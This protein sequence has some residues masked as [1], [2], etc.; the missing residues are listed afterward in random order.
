MAWL[1]QSHRLKREFGDDAPWS[2]GWR[3]P[4]GRSQSRKIGSRSRAEKFA[5]KIEGQIAAGTYEVVQRKTWDGFREKY[6]AYLL[7]NLAPT[8]RES[9]GIALDHFE[10][11]VKPRRLQTINAEAVDR[12][13]SLRRSEKGQKSATVSVA[14]VNR[15]LRVIKAAL[16]VANEWEYLAKVPKIRMLREPKKLP[17]YVTPAHFAIIY[18]ACQFATKPKGLPYAAADWWKALVTF[19]YLT[20]WRIS[21]PLALMRK[22][23]DLDAGQVVTRAAHNKGKRDDLVPVH[24]VV[25]EH[26]QKL[27]SFSPRMFPWPHNRRTLWLEFHHIQESAVDADGKR[28]INLPCPEEGEHGHTCNE[29]CH[30][31]G[32]H[33]LR[34]AFA[35]V[36]AEMMTADSLQTLMRHKS[37]TTT[38]RYIN[39]A[40]QVNRAVEKI[41]VPEILTKKQA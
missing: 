36:N 24:P 8:S 11:L 12:Y 39:L 15:E 31:Y 9:A 16:R 5:R 41:H 26:L 23:V 14:T 1:Y 27:A 30:V 4:D 28:L 34:R 18:E 35:T 19:C 17:S 21:E 6:D 32:F 38:Q 2:V 20:G 29:T 13:V 10:R 37:Y 22:D 25:V 3:D 40:Q 33:D 7:E